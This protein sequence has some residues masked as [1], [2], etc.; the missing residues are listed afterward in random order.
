MSHQ[1]DVL[2]VDVRLP[3]SMRD[4]EFEVAR[5]TVTPVHRERSAGHVLKRAPHDDITMT[6]QKLAEDR[7]VFKRSLRPE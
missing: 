1:A 5:R 4:Q 2:P 7:V 3:A 6:G